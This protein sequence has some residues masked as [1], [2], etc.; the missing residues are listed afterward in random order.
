L[1]YALPG[2]LAHYATGGEWRYSPHLSLIENCLLD[3]VAGRIDRLMVSVPP[4]HGKSTIISH[5]FPTWY[6]GRFPGKKCILTSYEATFASSWGRKA[7][8]TLEEYGPRIFNVNVSDKS[9]ASDN[10]EVVHINE[11]NRKIISSM[12][13]AGAGGPIT[14]KGADLMIIDDPVKNNEEALSSTRLE[15]IFEWYQ[16][17]VY[18]RL[19]PTAAII[20]VMTRWSHDDLC[21]KLIREQD[22]G[23]DTWKIV[24]LPALI[25]DEDMAR[26]DPLGRE[27]GD[28]LWPE[29]YP[30]KWIKQ[31]KRVL[32]SFWFEALYQQRPAPKAGFIVNI[33]WFRRY[34]TQPAKSKAEMVVLS[35]DT[36]QKEKEL[37]DYTVCTVWFIYENGYYLIDVIRDRFSHPALLS[38]AKNLIARWTPNVVLVEDKGS[39]TSLIQHLQ[40]ETTAP[41]IPMDPTS[42][43]DKAIRMEVECPVIEA[44]Q[45]YL[46]ESG[47]AEWLYDFVEELRS[48][49]NSAYKDQAD[50]VSQFL[51]WAREKRTGIMMW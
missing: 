18:T 31:R 15:K 39:G 19:S 27:I 40:E 42:A 24:T 38:L 28:S 23:G 4:Q 32:Q 22:V 49:P 35:F 13:T 9:A 6:L 14:G 33:E 34:K 51:R 5:Y 2:G 7:R 16:S 50:S 25:E 47:R 20:I 10:W 11:Q 44:G 17:T 12:V 29:R 30:A 3:V 46:P 37:N 48:F 43:G 21:G 36:A 1:A 26:A 8:D 45:C 41:V